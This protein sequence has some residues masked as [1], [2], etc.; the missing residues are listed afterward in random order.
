MPVDS[1]HSPD[2]EHY[3]QIA[4]L[5][6]G[7]LVTQLLY[8]AVKLGVI[9]ALAEA[10]ATATDLA[11]AIGANPQALHRVLR[12]LAAEAILDE[13]PGERFALTDLGS[14]LRTDDPAGLGGAAL[15]RGSLYFRAAGAL[16]DAVRAGGV[17][18][19][20]VYAEPMFAYLAEHPDLREEFLQSMGARSRREAV[21]VAASYDF[22]PY[23]HLVDVG[24]GTGTLLHHLLRHQPHLRGTLFDRPEVVRDAQ[25]SL[26]TSSV[27]DRCAFAPGDFFEA[28]TEG[29]D[30]M[31]LSRVIHDWDDDDAQRILATCHKALQPGATLLLVET[32]LPERAAENPPA[33]RMDLHMLLITSGHE[34]TAADFGRLLSR[35][36]FAPPRFIRTSSPLGVTIVETTALDR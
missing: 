29:G 9:D 13:Q 35:T 21:D 28:V 15:P 14:C 10:P 27:A 12:G 34:R 22:G 17:P 33:I 32:L 11:A 23:R 36:G 20:H 4:R 31:V 24:G 5:M 3:L 6:D 1:A 2:P 19:E 7:Y 26:G 18:F 25:R 30:I 16:V 8:V